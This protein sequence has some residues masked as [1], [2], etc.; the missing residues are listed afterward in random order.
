M[1]GSKDVAPSNEILLDSTAELKKPKIE[2]NEL[3]LSLPN[4]HDAVGSNPEL[5]RLSESM[6]NSLRKTHRLIAE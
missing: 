3:R 6:D 4:Y 1:K 5:H 2:D